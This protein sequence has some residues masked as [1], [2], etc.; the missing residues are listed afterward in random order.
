[1][2]DTTKYVIKRSNFPSRIYL[3][4]TV[5]F[6]LIL[7]RFKVSEIWWGVGIT[8]WTFMNVGA[9]IMIYKENQKDVF[10]GEVS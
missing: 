9:V 7:D 1:M 8:F 10:T 6:F 2:S 5:V 4:E 3:W